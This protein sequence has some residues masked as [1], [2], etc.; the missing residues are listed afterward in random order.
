LAEIGKI[1]WQHNESLCAALNEG[2]REVLADLL[3]RIADREGLTPG[4]HSGFGRLGEKGP[5]TGAL[6]EDKIEP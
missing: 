2:E 5:P 3:Q 4:V 1:A 6:S